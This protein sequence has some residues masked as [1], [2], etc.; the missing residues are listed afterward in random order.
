MKNKLIYNY[1]STPDLFIINYGI[2]TTNNLIVNYY[3]V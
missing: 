3:L 1:S 2:V